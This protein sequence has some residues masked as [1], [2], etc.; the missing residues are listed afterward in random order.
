MTDCLHPTHDYDHVMD[1]FTAMVFSG[2]EPMELPSGAY[3]FH[4]Q[5][6]VRFV[7]LIEDGKICLERVQSTGKVTCFQRAEQGDVLAEASVYAD[8]YHCDA[9]VLE[10][11]R[12]RRLK[13]ADFTSLLRNDPNLAETWAAR[14]A[15]TVQTTRLVSEI[16]SFKTVGD[17]LDAWLGDFRELPSKGQWHSLAHELAVSPEALYRELAKRRV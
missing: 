10:D 5:D 4:A 14:L 16:R 6:K 1:D 2:A 3:L 12:L 8:E 15:R 7:H 17:R 13:K 11:V 9:R